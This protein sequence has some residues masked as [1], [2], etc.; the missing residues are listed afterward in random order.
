MITLMTGVARYCVT[1]VLRTVSRRRAVNELWYFSNFPLLHSWYLGVVPGPPLAEF[2]V[3]RL[4]PHRRPF[5]YIP[6]SS[7]FIRYY[8]NAEFLSRPA[9]ICLP[10]VLYSMTRSHI[11]FEL[12]YYSE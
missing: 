4:S 10:V 9:K 3:H 1:P 12:I 7:R 8:K 11:S 2:G 6:P 5:L